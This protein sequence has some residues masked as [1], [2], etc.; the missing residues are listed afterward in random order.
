MDYLE[1]EKEMAKTYNAIAT[2][3]EKETDE[4]WKNK[5]FVDK[6]L[7]HINKDSSI[8]DIACGTGELLKYYQEKG[9]LSTGIDIATE[10]INIARVKVPEANVLE[11]SLYDIDRLEE[12][13]DGISA[14]FILV[15]IP[16]DKIREFIKNIRDRLKNDGVFFTIFGT[17]IKEGI[18]QEP[19]DTRYKY[20]AINY[21][22]D[23]II[24][25]LCEN[26]FEI[27]ESVQKSRENRSDIAIIIAKKADIK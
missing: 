12:M 16:K 5:E 20:Y 17:S 14:T 15:H 25:L 27:V 7:K 19:L 2:K 10:M 26:G 23:E 8:L 4:N 18:Q 22:K 11:M 6:F 24:N 21:S 3:Y 13:F 9:F 1:I